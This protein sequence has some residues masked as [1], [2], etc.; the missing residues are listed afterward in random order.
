MSSCPRGAVVSVGRPGGLVH[1]VSLRPG[2][3]VVWVAM[4]FVVDHHLAIQVALIGIGTPCPQTGTCGP[5]IRS[6]W[7][8]RLC[9]TIARVVVHVHV[10]AVP[11]R[12]RSAG[13]LPG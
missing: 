8:T 6:R 11:P 13:G 5:K 3:A 9:G 10:H 12:P 1:A 7:S 2:N 4:N